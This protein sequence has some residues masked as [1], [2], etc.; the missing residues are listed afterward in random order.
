MPDT[1]E[2]LIAYCQQNGRVCPLPV[3]WD[4]LWQLLPNRRQR[5]VGW[6]PPL[7]MILAG[8]SASHQSKMLRL[9]QH[10]EWAEKRGVLGDAAAFLRSLREE[11]WYHAED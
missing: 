4:Q 1:V 3:F 8:W 5:G 2:S 7:P 9:V 11:D 6:E 10:I